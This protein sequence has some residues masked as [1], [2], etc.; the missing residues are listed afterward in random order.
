MN[1]LDGSCGVLGLKKTLQIEK[2]R[3][4]EPTSTAASAFLE[5]SWYFMCKKRSSRNSATRSKLSHASS[6][7][8]HT[9]Q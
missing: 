6:A 5:I 2:N 1:L 3:S 7:R 4:V 9:P 8:V